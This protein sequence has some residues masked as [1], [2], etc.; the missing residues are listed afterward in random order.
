M[1][2]TVNRPGEETNEASLSPTDSDATQ[3]HELNR[4]VSIAYMQSIEDIPSDSNSPDK[5]AERVLIQ[6]AA[7][8]TAVSKPDDHEPRDNF[9]KRSEGGHSSDAVDRSDKTDRKMT[10]ENRDSKKAI[11]SD[12]DTMS[13]SVGINVVISSAVEVDNSVDASSTNTAAVSS[14]ADANSSSSTDAMSAGLDVI[15]KNDVTDNTDVKQDESSQ[16]QEQL[17]LW[18]LAFEREHGRPPTAEDILKNEHAKGI[19]KRLKKVR[20]TG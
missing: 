15:S 18:S 17:E 4:G 12:A 5:E 2:S 13:S 16:Y 8:A 6:S 19:L 7:N 3:I 14:S 11:N 1:Q 20:N 10:P 9:E